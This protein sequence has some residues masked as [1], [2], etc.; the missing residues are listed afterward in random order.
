MSSV[1]MP[2][3]S[4]LASMLRRRIVQLA[5]RVSNISFTCKWIN[6]TSSCQRCLLVAWNVRIQQLVSSAC[7]CASARA[8]AEEMITLWVSRKWYLRCDNGIQKSLEIVLSEN[9]LWHMNAAWNEKELTHDTGVVLN[10]YTFRHLPLHCARWGSG[11]SGVATQTQIDYRQT[12]EIPR[13][14]PKWE[15]E[16]GRCK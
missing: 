14:L 5:L 3:V 8:G 15:G 7:V 1:C 11:A 9:R 16:M 4:H 6:F 13:D 2:S 12:L 10:H